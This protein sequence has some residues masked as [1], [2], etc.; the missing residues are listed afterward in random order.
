MSCIRK[1]CDNVSYSKEKK[2]KLEELEESIVF[3]RNIVS[4]ADTIIQ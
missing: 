4:D 1:I 2:G 3:L